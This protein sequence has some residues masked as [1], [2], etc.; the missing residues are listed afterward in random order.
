MWWTRKGEA[1]RDGFEPWRF[2]ESAAWLGPF[3]LSGRH[4]AMTESLAYAAVAAPILNV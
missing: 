4:P 2:C 3:Q 1:G